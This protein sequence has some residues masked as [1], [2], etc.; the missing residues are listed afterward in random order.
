M[1]AGEIGCLEVDSEHNAFP[2]CVDQMRMY[3]SQPGDRSA[4]GGPSPR[5]VPSVA[6][7]SLLFVCASNFRSQLDRLLDLVLWWCD[8]CE[9]NRW[10]TDPNVG[11]GGV[12]PVYIDVIAEGV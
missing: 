10:C 4:V 8:S 1:C 11:P 3:P 7:E 2:P 12:L 9:L 5:R 6:L